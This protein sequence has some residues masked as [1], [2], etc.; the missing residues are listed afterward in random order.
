[1]TTRLRNV[2][3][4]VPA[5]DF[6]QVVDF[7]GQALGARTVPQQVGPFTHLAAMPGLLGLHL[8][9]LDEGD[10]RVHLDLEVADV[11]VETERLI[12][13]GAIRVGD[14]AGG[15]I[16]TDPAGNVFCVVYTGSDDVLRVATDDDLRLQVLVID[17][18]SES[19]QAAGEFW[20]QAFGVQAEHLPEPFDA[21]IRVEGAP[22][23]GGPIRVL[24]Q[25]IGAG[26]APRV[27][28][29]LHV[30]DGAARDRHVERLEGLGATVVE[31][32]YPWTV[33]TDPVGTV[34]CVVPDNSDPQ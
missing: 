24:V 19:F 34:F 32:T 31:R 27:H 6:D 5:D 14:G 17:V 20:G 8:Q 10:P 30:P 4:D 33:M 25:D 29:D 2:Q 13:L 12:D 18:A 15:P 28:L 22:A 1:V 3:I 16:L 7:W 9:R 11:E 21:Y 23:V 26:A